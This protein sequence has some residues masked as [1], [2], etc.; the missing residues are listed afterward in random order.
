MGKEETIAKSL[1]KALDSMKRAERMFSSGIYLFNLQY[2]FHCLI[3]F[4]YVLIIRMVFVCEN[5][6]SHVIFFVF[7]CSWLLNLN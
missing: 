7:S 1:G 3:C 4:K 5:S 6:R 2:I